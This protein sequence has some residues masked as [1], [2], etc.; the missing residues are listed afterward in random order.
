MLTAKNKVEEW[1]YHPNPQDKFTISIVQAAESKALRYF[2]RRCLAWWE[3]CLLIASG[4]PVC[5]SHLMMVTQISIVLKCSPRP[6]RPPN[7][8]RL[9]TG[10]ATVIVGDADAL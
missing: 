9:A 5:C 1:P 3:L 10:S 6:T 2:C 8:F 7:A 4:K